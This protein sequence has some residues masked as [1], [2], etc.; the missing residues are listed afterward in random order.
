MPFT[1]SASAVGTMLRLKNWLTADPRKLNTPRFDYD[2]HV[3]PSLAVLSL[4]D[5]GPLRVMFVLTS[6]PVGGAETL[7]VEL[8]RRL[9]RARF[10]PELC[11]LK[12]LGPLG[13]C[14]PAKS[15]RIPACCGQSTTSPCSGGWRG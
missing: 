1:C 9:D 13:E 7:V 10:L 14:W 5:R 2:C 3:S 15:P 8:I 6:M 11:C 12:E 4:E